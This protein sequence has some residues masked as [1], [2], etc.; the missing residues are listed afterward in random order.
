VLEGKR[1]TTWLFFPKRDS[2]CGAP[3][4]LE[5]VGARLGCNQAVIPCDETKIALGC[6]NFPV[7]LSNIFGTDEIYDLDCTG[8]P[9]GKLCLALLLGC[10]G[11]PRLQQFFE[12]LGSALCEY[13]TAGLAR[14]VPFETSLLEVSRYLH[15]RYAASPGTDLRT[16]FRELVSSPDETIELSILDALDDIRPTVPEEYRDALMSYMEVIPEVVRQALRRPGDPAGL[17]V[18]KEF[19]LKRVDDW[20]LF[21][22]H[23]LPTYRPG[24]IPIN[25]ETWRTEQLRGLGTHTEVWEGYDDEQPELSPA[26]LK[27]ITDEGAAEKFRSREE[28]LQ[29]I[30]DLE[31]INGLIPLRSVYLLSNPPCFEYIH[32]PGYDLANL[33]NDARWRGDRPRPSQAAM[34]MRRISRV[35]GKLHRQRKPMVHGGLKPSNVLLS[36]MDGKVS[37]WIS[38]IG[39]GEVSAGLPTENLIRPQIL[40]RSMRGSYAPLYAPP[41]KSKNL[42][43]D[44]RDD[45][46]AIG[47]IWYQLLMNDPAA[48]APIGLDW[49]YG[50]HQYGLTE[51]QAKLIMSCLSNTALDRP[52]DG[53]TLAD[54]IVSN[55]ASLRNGDSS[56]M[57]L[58]NSS[59]HTLRKASSR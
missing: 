45:I 37:I 16:V 41:K 15:R 26:C 50:L 9:G 23:Q 31:V 39:W 12:C 48:S 18:P 56:S 49:S 25:Q 52:A 46:Y 7:Y 19:S 35:V 30:L 6:L 54:L 1:V 40:R 33:M 28:L 20:L 51:G 55:S 57:S 34:I 38:D 22:P 42:P 53:L 21:L 24:D 59:L 5:G 10:I 3:S 14:L 13:A 8:S 32:L 58:S 44:P 11:M 4:V 27:F 36:P 43:I 2:P 47:M 17:S 29:R